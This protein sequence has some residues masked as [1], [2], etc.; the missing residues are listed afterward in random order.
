MGS[1]IS[2]KFTKN[3]ICALLTLLIMIANLFSPYSV[4]VNNTYATV[5]PSGEPYFK[6]RMA[7]IDSSGDYS[8][9]SDDTLYYYYDYDEKTDTPETYTGDRIIKFY[10]TLQGSSYISGGAISLKYDTNKLIPAE[11]GQMKVGKYFVPFVQQATSFQ[12]PDVTTSFGEQKWP[13]PAIST[14][15]TS[16]GTIR[17]DGGNTTFMNNGDLICTF[18]FYIKEGVAL[19]D[20]NENV[21]TL[22]PGASLQSGLKINYKPSGDWQGEEQSVFGND[23]FVY[24]GFA[25][26][27]KTIT[28][29]TL[30]TNMD[31]TK[32]YVGEDLDFT[33]ASIT[34]TYDN[35]DTETITDISK[36]VEDGLIT[37]DETKASANKKVV[38]TA[39]E[40]TCDISYNIVTGISVSQNPTKT[41]YEHGDTIDLTGGKVTVTYDNGDTEEID[42]TSSLLTSTPTIADVNNGV[43][44]LCYKDG[45][46]TTTVPLTVTD[47]V[48]SI[49]IT[50]NPNIVEY[51]DTNPIDF[52]GGT[53][54]ATKKSGAE[55]T[56]ISMTDSAVTKSAT[57]A[58]INSCTDKTI[59]DITGL[60]VG[61]QAIT[62]TYEGKS[63]TFD[64]LVNDTISTIA[65][66]NQPTSKNKYGTAGNNLNLTG[67]TLEITTVSGHTLTTPINVGM[68]D[69]SSYDPN[70]L[71]M[72]NITVNYAGKTTTSGNGIDITLKDYIT[73]IT[74]TAPNDLTTNY[75]EELDLSNVTYVKNYASGATSSANQVTSDM[76][77]GYSKKP[78]ANEFDS[79]HECA[80]TITVTLNTPDD[81]DID[82]IPVD[83][84]F[85]VTVKDKVNGITIYQRP[86]NTTYNYGDS[87]FN[88]AGGRIKRSYESGAV[89][90][91]N[92]V[93]MID[94]N[95][96]ITEMDGSTINMSPAASEFKN[97]KVIKTLKVTYTDDNG[98]TYSADL[99]NIIIKDIFKSMEIKQQPEKTFNHGVTFDVGSGTLELTY[100]SGSKKE[101]DLDDGTTITETATGTTVD[102]SP[103]SYT[104]D[105]KIT[106]NITVSYSEGTVT[107]TVN[108]DITIINDI[109]SITVHSTNHKTEYNVNDELDKTNLEILVTRAIGAPEVISDTSKFTVTDF[110]SATENTSLPLTVSYE[111]NGITKTTT[112]NVTVKDSVTSI[113][114][115]NPPTVLKYGENLDLT[116]TTISIT[117]GSNNGKTI[118]VTESMISY[119]KTAIGTV[120]VTVKYGKDADGN[121]VTDTFDITV[122]DYV[123]GITINKTEIEGT[124]G[125]TLNDL[126]S[127]NSLNYTV[128]YAKAGQQPPV[129]LEEAMV[130]VYN[131]EATTDQ[132][133]TVTYI[134]NDSGSFTN[135]GRFTA[136]LK[137]KF[138]NTVTEITITAPT[139]T[140]YNHGESLIL[141]GGVINLTYAD[142]TL[143]TEP[144]T[145]A[146][147]KETDGSEVNMSPATYDA[148]NKISKTLVITYTKDGKTGTVNYP[149]EIINDI[150]SITVH[151]TK[152]KTEYNVND[153]LDKTNLE[154]LVTRATGTPEVI[155]DTSKFTVTDFSSATENTS[156]PL[157]VSYEENGITKTTTYNVTVKDSVTSITVQNPPT[158]LKY[159][160]NLDL[161]NTTISITGGSNNGKTIPVTESMISY[162]KTAIGTVSVTVKYGKDADGNDVT[163]TFDITVKDY[164]KGITINPATVTGTYNDTLADIISDNTI[165][166]T[167]TYAYAGQQLPVD[168]SEAMVAGYNATSTTKQNLTVTYTDT[169]PEIYAGAN[170][171]QATLNITLSDKI[172]GVTVTGTAEN[173]T[174]NHGEVLDFTGISIYEQHASD[175][176]DSKGTPV[177]IE[178]A[179]I[180]DITDGETGAPIATTNLPANVFTTNNTQTRKIRVQYTSNG[181][182][183]HIDF[184]ITVKNILDRIEIATSPKTSYEKG[185]SIE[186]AGGTIK[187][188]RKADKT[189]STEIINITDDMI[190]G[191]DT[192][193]VGQ[194]LEAT[195][196]YEEEDAHGKK[197]I[198]DDTY[199]YNVIETVQS[200]TLNPGPDKTT[201]KYGESINL[202][203]AY[204]DIVKGN[205]V[206]DRIAV[207]ENMIS[208][209]NSTP[210]ASDLPDTQ[211]ITVTYGKHVDGTPATVTFT[212]TVEDEVIGIKLTPP[213]KTTYKYGE[214]LDLSTG[215]V[216]KVMASGA[217]TPKVPLTDNSVKV[218]GFDPKKIGSQTITVKY[219]GE[220]KTF[221]VVVE[222]NAISIK[223]VEYPKQNYEYGEQLDITG[224][225][226]EVTRENGDKEI[227]PMTKDMVT[228]FNPNQAGQQK[229]TV[230]Y[231][232]QKDFYNIEVTDDIAGI[233]ITPPKKLVYNIGEKID[234]TGGKVTEITASGNTKTPVDM[235]L[236]MISGFNTSS[237][238]AKTIT[239]TYKGKKATF[240]ITVVDPLSDVQIVTLPDK[241]T[242][243]YGEKLD[244]TGGTIQTITA[245]GEKQTIKMTPE[246]ITGYNP[247]KLGQQTLKVTYEGI[248]KEFI[249]TVEDYITKLV[250]KAP[251]KKEYEYG[252][253]LNLTGGKVSII[254]ASGA[255][256]ENV[257]M[258]AS[259]ISGYN[260]TKEGTQ[261][262]NVEY[263]GLQGTFQVKVIDK[264]K[265]IAINTLP[266][267]TDYK[268]GEN[269]SLTGGTI[270]VIKSSGTQIIPI[271][272][273]MVTGY[274]SKKAGQQV[275]TVS[276]GGFTTEFV[277]KVAKKTSTTPSTK[278]SKPSTKPIIKPAPTPV[279]P[280]IEEPPM[281]EE[282]IIEEPIIQEPITP[283]EQ[284]IIENPKVE[285]PIIEKPTQVL[286][287]K[288]EQNNNNGK[289]LAGCIGAIG[290][291]FLLILIIFRRNVKIYVYEDGEFVLGGKDKITKKNPRIDIDKFLDKVTYPNQVKILLN[292]T[293]S[294]KLD[295]KEIEINHR[296]KTIKHTIK[297]NYEEYEIILK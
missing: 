189:N 203:G 245:S 176:Q 290:L 81:A 289:I 33:G 44:N 220:T 267:K 140:T 8:S 27:E 122:K 57:N 204:L 96:S 209:F 87:T 9:W 29:I 7:T 68:L 292:D 281:I 265:G 16:A 71:S 35:G 241:L 80:Q 252:E 48:V 3:R 223:I 130:A 63:D 180:T 280:P 285:E 271:T 274:D 12:N 215:F 82:E 147:I 103:T 141:T 275:I 169:N 158:V 101:I 291:L 93:S 182:E 268:N 40:E 22:T 38:I 256:E 192:S 115:Q 53:I 72:Q 58:D 286:G 109:K 20:L 159:G 36:A 188:Y 162:D 213:D 238:G 233:K 270:T 181:Y 272:K 78:N 190:T 119:D 123:T 131:P 253:D 153:E 187:I 129:D 228:G 116:N 142:G 138:K 210:N 4:L 117:G 163:D 156:L 237:E 231:G 5:P 13:Y 157:T 133:L 15:D 94:P 177:S 174:Y 135:G 144:I 208:G 259:M 95:V 83:D 24:E 41:E 136:P 152:H 28:S 155:S 234:L 240:N 50:N 108:Y 18:M 214:E 19:S 70:T 84:N 2:E 99:N 244:I 264:I 62:V 185:D 112:Y 42:M 248:T 171:A 191:L 255:V 235:T 277:V 125:K 143:D 170:S 121:D 227:I 198:K 161:T 146:T 178:N 37:I 278:P 196:T 113:T 64:I 222:E 134:D 1:Q 218:T 26:P 279:E 219:E 30:D 260:K 23:H 124:K 61:K 127:D 32:Y 66:K 34:I 89:D 262:I 164:V 52:T 67:A 139:K 105:N 165:K 86:N 91:G 251:D 137:V 59:N 287:V 120:S 107:D 43:I 100:E 128:T 85:S 257:E 293:I 276:Y 263:K 114:V 236:D 54:K 273:D 247:N 205:G 179:T 175:A 73:G 207:T 166:Y 90:T 294:E 25:A 284:P 45:V 97:G 224:G 229:L 168:L 79:N 197:I 149:I 254:M 295:G 39:G 132:Q 10:L 17:L 226:I 266:N 246:M 221:P 11:E 76:T 232:G 51:D 242:Y 283:I 243:K 296:G 212:V 106:K 69:L 250:V 148:T 21:I 77:S 183:G 47:P 269:L 211:T 239:V 160:E 288:D 172:T 75:N 55:I 249:V 258:T 46:T 167:V 150:K 230:T 14:L 118:P 206:T 184:D 195:V 282:P 49:T 194:N 186:N 56:G 201:Y 111:E 297:Y 102:M 110:S 65:V 173:T 261:T 145:S 31:K 217:Q 193:V 74:V 199:Q 126:I 225:K 154:I 202:T 60:P 216:Q 6:L 104:S 92:G 88:A 151:S 200:I 98:A